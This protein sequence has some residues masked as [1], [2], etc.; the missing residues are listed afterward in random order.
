MSF[1]VSN[2]LPTNLQFFHSCWFLETE[3]FSV[4]DSL[5]NRFLSFKTSGMMISIFSNTVLFVDAQ[6]MLSAYCWSSVKTRFSVC[7]YP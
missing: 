7:S 3:Y 2:L 5:T 6:L 1:T 4:L